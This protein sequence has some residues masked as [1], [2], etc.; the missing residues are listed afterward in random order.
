MSAAVHEAGPGPFADHEALL[1]SASRAPAGAAADAS[2]WWVLRVVLPALLTAAVVAD[3]VIWTEVSAPCSPADPCTWP[4][5]V[6]VLEGLLLASTALAWVV[7]VVGLPLAAASGAAYALVS[8]EVGDPLLLVL[9]APAVQV[10][11]G[12]AGAVLAVRSR[13]ARRGLGAALPTRAATG[14]LPVRGR[15]VL[16]VRGLVVTDLLA[17]AALLAAVALGGWWTAQQARLA[18]HLAVAEPAVVEVVAVDDWDWLVEVELPGGQTVV[19]DDT[20]EPLDHSPGDRLPALVDLSGPEPW[21]SLDGEPEEESG[22]LL[23][24][25]AAL[26]LGL[27]LAASR[28]RVLRRRRA[29][30]RD[31]GRLWRTTSV[32]AESGAAVLLPEL[33]LRLPVARTTP[34]DEVLDGVG[35]ARHGAWADTRLREAVAPDEDDDPLGAAEQRGFA[36]AWRGDADPDLLDDEAADD[37]E[38]A[39][40]TV[41][42][43]DPHL[44]G[45]ALAVTADLVLVPCGA[46]AP[47]SP[48][49]REWAEGFAASPDGAVLADGE[50]L[51]RH[52]LP[53]RPVAPLPGSGP[54]LTAAGPL[55]RLDLSL[56]RRR[57]LLAL[58]LLLVPVAVWLALD[59]LV[60]EG[61]AGVLDVLWPFLALGVPALGGLAAS[62]ARVRC[63]QEGV[64]VRDAGLV[65]RLAWSD[66]VGARVVDG[67][68]VLALGVDAD[69]DLEAVGGRPPAGLGAARAAGLAERWRRDARDAPAG[70]GL[71]PDPVVAL[72]AVVHVALAAAVLA[73]HLAG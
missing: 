11:A 30:L 43:G 28:A 63:E 35:L 23:L 1:A 53:G 62:R 13:A 37:L 57:R 39:E 73:H 67:E 34:V 27:P 56:P 64:L 9:L 71:R 59:P 25:A 65:R 54:L 24:A 69:G 52:G 49:D 3:A 36:A 5:P 8:Y 21:V 26:A 18:E 12:L 68:V 47:M 50:G 29:L 22:W 48:S 55:D 31:G 42:V 6:A 44:G 7:P 38:A 66:V 16:A 20:Y 51:D 14:V 15:E 41:L 10:A 72:A 4:G 17:V 2:T 45:V 19:L 60:E 46:L 58:S 61:G 70:P 33:G 40:P 32:P